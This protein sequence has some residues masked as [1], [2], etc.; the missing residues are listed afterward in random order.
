M[1]ALSVVGSWRVIAVRGL[2]LL[3]LLCTA[4]FPVVGQTAVPAEGEMSLDAADSGADLEPDPEDVTTIKLGLGA[5]AVP[6]FE[7]AKDH[8]LF[9]IPIIEIQN[10]HRFSLSFRGLTY[11]L[12]HYENDEEDAFKKVEFRLEPALSPSV[13]RKEDNDFLFFTR[14][15]SKYLRGLGDIDTGLDVGANIFLR[16]GPVATQL[17][18]RQE[19]A[20][21]HSG[22]TAR[23]G[24]GTRIPITPRTRLGVELATTWADASYMDAFF[25]IDRAQAFRSIYRR[26][27]AG[28]DF[29]DASFGLRLDHEITDRVSLLT[30]AQYTRLMGDAADSPIVTGPGGSR[31]Q[32]TVLLGLTYSWRFG[33]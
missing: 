3:T 32:F 22:F 8:T 2:A 31:D 27:D 4:A 6:D 7:G 33:G 18:L 26:Y 20:G 30:A 24:F 10:F 11:A 17:A 28:A 21:G 23:L 5:L 1:Q 9:P 15:D 29:K 12:Y 25:S 14:G 19:V 16:T 13:S